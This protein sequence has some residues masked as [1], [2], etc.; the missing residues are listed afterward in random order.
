MDASGTPVLLAH[1]CFIAHD[2]KQ[3]RKMRPY[4]PLATLLTAAVV[5]GSGRRVDLFDAMLSSG[6]EEFE[7]LVWRLRPR[8]VGLLEDNFNFLAKMC[9]QRSR[10]AAVRLIR[11]AKAAGA[12]V[13]VNGPDATDAPGYYL[14]VGADAV[15]L[16]ET[17]RT[18]LALLEA[19]ELGADPSSIPG[20]ALAAGPVRAA[21]TLPVR[22]PPRPFVD[23]L[24][25]LPFPAWDLVDV[26]RYRAAW[27]GA[28]GRLSWNMVTTRGCPYRCNWCAKPVYGTRYAQRS[29]ENVA[30][31]MGR[32][33]ETIRP[34][35]VW[36]ADDIFGLSH[37]WIE[38]FAEAVRERGAAIPFTIQSRVDL[39][40]ASA[41][42]ALR[43]AGAEEVW[44][45]VESGAQSILDAMDKGTT[46][47]QVREATRRLK[48]AEIR[49]AWFL[50]LGYPGE[51]WD[52]ILATRDLVREERPADVGVSVAYPLPGTVFHDRV[53]SQLSGRS[54][55]KD[56]DD[57]AMMFEGTYSAP[58]YRL[59]RDLLHEEAAVA[60]IPPSETI[61]RRRRNL[62]AAWERA[63]REEAGYRTGEGEASSGLR[64]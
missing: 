3:V 24:D 11:S 61:G 34:D 4:A 60:S 12:R 59:V 39:M 14:D 53:R 46:V 2:P 28:H 32:L 50:Q 51:T 64:G 52:E 35:H 37:R 25:T 33:K 13:A 42:E 30:D 57:L 40:S 63:G 49:P 55:W 17:E 19:W 6:E 20:L 58:F 41:V 44:M 31:E 5:R 26:E 43:H 62:D 29:P 54:H 56:S 8:F 27:T 9:T 36:F 21:G 16:G 22:T 18:F 23:D 38:R 7:A 15:I 47:E 48:D 45:G 1:S 10:E